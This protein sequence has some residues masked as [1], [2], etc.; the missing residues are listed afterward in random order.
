MN[1]HERLHAARLT[2]L[3]G[4]HEEALQEYIWFH[5]HALEEDPA[6]SGV[7][8]SFA[9]GHWTDLGEVYPAALRALEGIRE[10]K[11]AALLNGSESW[12]VFRDVVA[13]NEA[14]ETSSR[15]YE[16]FVKLV[17]SKPAFARKCAAIALPA[18]VDANDFKLSKQ[19][20]PVPETEILREATWLNKDERQPRESDAHASLRRWAHVRNFVRLVQLHM[21]I[22]T[23]NGEPA[24]A[25]SLKALA[26]NFIESPSL[27]AAVESEFV[28]PSEAP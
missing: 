27:R 11:A 3:E 20:S 18:I 2:A 28:T 1:A 26:L 9:L 13:I 12:D 4:K 23:G 17:E 24:D 19:V 14:L 22:A 25:A 21:A 16:L 8:L 6:L 5:H 15:T 10:Q 7:R